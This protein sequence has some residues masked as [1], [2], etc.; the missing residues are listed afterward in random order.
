MSKTQTVKEHLIDLVK[1]NL[2]TLL[3]L[4]DTQFPGLG[5]GLGVAYAYYSQGEQRKFESFCKELE[6][7]LKKSAFEIEELKKRFENQAYFIIEVINL[8]LK[9]KHED[10]IKFYAGAVAEAIQAVSEEVAERDLKVEFVK[11]ISDLSNFELIVLEAMAR[12][13]R[14]EVWDIPTRKGSGFLVPGVEINPT[15][16]SWIDLLIQKGLVSD[17]SIEKIQQGV[18]LSQAR[19]TGRSSIRISDF[20]RSVIAY[21]LNF[22]KEES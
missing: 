17:V 16:L 4:I 15:T 18:G 8:M 13:Q 5:M 20:G 2:P 12:R 3:P 14:G 19:V 6:N 1:G 11:V 21:M 7:Q 9:E 22:K 10:R